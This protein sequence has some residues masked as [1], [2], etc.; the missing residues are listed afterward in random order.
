MK[1]VGWSWLF[2][3]LRL[4]GVAVN[5]SGKPKEHGSYVRGPSWDPYVKSQV[6]PQDGP[7]AVHNIHASS[8]WL[9]L[10]NLNLPYFGDSIQV[11]ACLLHLSWVAI[12]E[13]EL[14]MIARYNT[15]CGLVALCIIGCGLWLRNLKL[16]CRHLGTLYIVWLTYHSIAKHPK[17]LSSVVFTARLVMEG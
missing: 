10:N 13:L 7:A 15:S 16:T 1:V 8:Y 4:I 12:E 11:M 3:L 5:V 9:M 6:H 2:L 14:A 17:F